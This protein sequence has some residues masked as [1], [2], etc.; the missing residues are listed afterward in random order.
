MKNV[1]S[2]TLT[3]AT[4]N[5]SEIFV[6][7]KTWINYAHGKPFILNANKNMLTWLDKYYGFKSFPMLFDESYDNKDTFVDR[8]FYGV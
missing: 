8:V 3:R 1:S 4:S 7:E 2:A 5:Q 6:T